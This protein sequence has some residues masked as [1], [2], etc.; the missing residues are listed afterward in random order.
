MLW[1]G[2]EREDKTFKHPFSP[3]HPPTHPFFPKPSA[4]T[5]RL[6]NG[7]SEKVAL[8]RVCPL[9]CSIAQ[10]APGQVA[11]T[12]ERSCLICH[13]LARA[14]STCDWADEHCLSR[15]ILALTSRHC[16]KLQPCSEPVPGADHPVGGTASLL[17]PAGCLGGP[18]KSL[19]ISHSHLEAAIPSMGCYCLVQ[20]VLANATHWPV[21]CR[22]NIP[23]VSCGLRKKRQ[24]H[25]TMSFPYSGI[26]LCSL[27]GCTGWVSPNQSSLACGY[28]HLNS[29]LRPT[30]TSPQ[31]PALC[32]P[33]TK[34]GVLPAPFLN[35]EWRAKNCYCTFWVCI[36]SKW[37]FGAT[38]HLTGHACG[39][40][41]FGTVISTL[42][43][44]SGTGDDSFGWP[45]ASKLRPH[46]PGAQTNSR[47]E[48]GNVGCAP[49]LHTSKTPKNLCIGIGSLELNIK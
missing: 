49:H 16:V 30:P 43:V 24:V 6:S 40:P 18:K 48:W 22:A 36:T 33:M 12:Q 14:H 47:G 2:S 44:L 1:V 37:I 21:A 45:A 9:G 3:T 19:G 20:L 31:L 15:S 26:L 46:S 5:G 11:A 27:N 13:L 23:L 8:H 38:V 41:L 42:W 35:Q 32:G 39:H 17:Q 4:S 34:Q 7:S 25:I 29:P 28:R 10:P